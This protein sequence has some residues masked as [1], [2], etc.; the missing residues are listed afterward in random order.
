[1]G[2]AF[3][4]PTYFSLFSQVKHMD[5]NDLKSG[6]A[7]AYEKGDVAVIMSSPEKIDGNMNVEIMIIRKELLADG[8]YMQKQHWDKYQKKFEGRISSQQ[9]KEYVIEAI[10]T[11][12]AFG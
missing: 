12:T 10:F 3:A 11:V 2:L 6:M 1:M 5:F 9:A 7:F 8:V 4:G